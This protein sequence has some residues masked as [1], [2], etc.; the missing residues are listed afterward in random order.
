MAIHGE[1]LTMANESVAYRFI[2]SDRLLDG[3]GSTVWVLAGF[4][5][6]AIQNALLRGIDLFSGIHIQNLRGRVYLFTHATNAFHCMFASAVFFLAGKSRRLLWADRAL[7]A[8]VGLGPLYLTRTAGFQYYTAPDYYATNVVLTL[9]AVFFFQSESRGQ[10]QSRPLFACILL[11]TLAGLMIANK[12]TLAPLCLLMLVPVLFTAEIQ[13]L[14]LAGRFSASAVS[15]VIAFM[16]VIWAFYVFN[17][18]AVFE[19]LHKWIPTI[20]DPGEHRDFQTL[21]E[22]TGVWGSA[23]WSDLSRYSYAYILAFWPVGVFLTLSVAIKEK[24]FDIR[25]AAILVANTIAAI[26]WTYFLLKRP[27]DTTFFETAVALLALSACALTLVAGTRN[28]KAII[29]AAL[30]G[31]VLFA[32]VTF[33]GRQN[34]LALHQSK[35]VADKLW[36]LQ[37]ELMKFAAGRRIIVIHPDNHHGYRG[38]PEFLLKGSADTPTWNVNKGGRRILRRYA[39]GMSFRHEY[40]GTRPDAPI[41]A[42]NVVY[43]VDLPWLPTLTASNPTLRE[44]VQQPFSEQRRW[45]IPYPFAGEG[46]NLT[47]HAVLL[48]ESIGAAALDLS[49]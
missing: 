18:S 7:L 20:F 42:G 28:G 19:M 43:W 36:R 17:L 9:T 5:I 29:A 15:T 48:H 10:F 40:S 45:T 39:P 1:P 35:L 30:I 46:V 21:M 37:E 27:A 11:G 8:L 49:R 32:A 2:Y 16:F 13:P 41:A 14:V 38:V 12:I 33:N 23:F 26:F 3:E 22:Q 44:A 47:A 34:I 6:T 25:V 31:W 4:L 24:L